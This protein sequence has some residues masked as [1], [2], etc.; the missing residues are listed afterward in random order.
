MDHPATT[1]SYIELGEV[2]LKY[3]NRTLL[4]HGLISVRESEA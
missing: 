3:P 2:Y 1:G 4:W